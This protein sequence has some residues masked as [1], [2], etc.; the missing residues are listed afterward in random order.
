MTNNT[1]VF[2]L[3]NFTKNPQMG[4]L[5]VQ[6]ATLLKVV[7]IKKHWL[8]ELKISPSLPDDVPRERNSGN[9]RSSHNFIHWHVHTIVV[10]LKP[11]DIFLGF[12]S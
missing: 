2:E 3:L 4:E 8:F 12:K 6:L 9:Q 5:K 7:G 11:S 1:I 10:K